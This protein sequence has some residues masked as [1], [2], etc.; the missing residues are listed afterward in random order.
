MSKNIFLIIKII[1]IS[2]SSQ[3]LLFVNVHFRHGARS[4][5]YYIDSNL[6]DYFGIKWENDGYLTFRGKFQAFLNGIKHRQKYS[7]FLSNTYN[8]N[9]II[10]YSSNFSRTISTCEN[11]LNGL[12][13]I[14]NNT[15]NYSN[16]NLNILYPPGNITNYQKLIAN[17][18]KNISTL[19]KIIN[20]SIINVY[21]IEQ[22]FFI[23]HDPDSGCKPIKKIRYDIYSSEKYRNISKQFKLKYGRKLTKYFNEIHKNKT[24]QLT[25]EFPEISSVCDTFKS[26][27]TDN[28]NISLLEKFDININ[29]FNN[30]CTNILSIVI[31]EIVSGDKNVVLM[32]QTPP[33]TQLIYWLDQRIKLD[34]E[35][36]TDEIV[37][38]SPKFTILSGHDT[39]VSTFEKWMQIFFGTKWIYPEFSSNYIIEL[40]KIG[41]NK[42]ELDYYV[43]DELFLKIDYYEFRKKVMNNLWDKYDILDFCKFSG[44]VKKKLETKKRIGLWL[45]ISMIVGLILLYIYVDKKEKE[46]EKEKED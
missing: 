27:F 29:E 33:L 41:K 26:D 16:E 22:H 43:D 15:K 2:F 9:E 30:Y 21:K 38:G 1:F 23:L 3:K 12:F 18:F 42:Y 8:P 34:K 4:P 36:K 39:S 20:D 35:N 7:K 45:S 19:P 10:A 11:Y 5:V 17:E 6:N 13:Y 44:N 24:L 46:K 32:S 31:N 37:K 28:K 25:F 14:N 40:N